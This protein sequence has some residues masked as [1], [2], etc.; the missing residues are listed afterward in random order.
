MRFALVRHGQTAWNAEGRI[1][2][3]LDTPMSEEGRKKMAA[4]APPKGFEHARAFSSPLLRARET[5]TLLGYPSPII[6]ARLLEHDWGR[7]QGL[8]RAEVLARDGDD[9]FERAGRAADFTPAGGER[10][11]DLVARVRSFLLDVGGREEDAIAITHRGVLRSAY[12]L[13]TGW[14]MLTP[15]PDALDLSKA[16]VLDITNGQITLA[17]LNAPLEPK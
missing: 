6:D 12:A 10:T 16:L 2:G 11:A 1:Q 14:Q 7:W 3:Q 8:T 5:A 13:A 17:Q 15:M 4:L 9:A